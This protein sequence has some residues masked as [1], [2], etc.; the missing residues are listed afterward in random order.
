MKKFIISLFIMI[1]LFSTAFVSLGYIKKNLRD[2][3][4]IT[5]SIIAAVEKNDFDFVKEKTIFL[6]KY[7]LLI[8][9]KMSIFT[10]NSEFDEITFN[11]AGLEKLANEESVA[12]LLH[13]C[14]RLNYIL[15]HI[16]LNEIIF[17]SNS[18]QGY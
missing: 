9:K 1:L 3:I 12:S 11:I 15:K 16:L 6:S 8:E 14:E 7:W 5:N 13:K 10:E 4:D 18:L 17:S 2:M